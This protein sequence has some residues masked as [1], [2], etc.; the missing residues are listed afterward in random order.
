[1]VTTEA[2]IR[3]IATISRISQSCFFLSFSIIPPLEILLL[4]D[5]MLS[6]LFIFNF[7]FFVILYFIFYCTCKLSINKSLIILIFIGSNS[8]ISKSFF[9]SPAGTF[10]KPEKKPPAYAGAVLEYLFYSI[11]SWYIHQIFCIFPFLFL[12]FHPH[13]FL[14]FRYHYHL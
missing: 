10:P 11:Q 2:A 1:M 7:S 4:Y 12:S 5:E 3:T 13:Y 8:F 14:F 6:Q 9:Q